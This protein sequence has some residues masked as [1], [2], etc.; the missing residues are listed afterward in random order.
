MATLEDVIKVQKL[1][2]QRSPVSQIN[3]FIQAMQQAQDAKRTRQSADADLQTKYANIAK[4]GV[5]VTKP[6]QQGGISGLLGAL[7]GK[8]QPMYD[9]DPTAYKSPMQQFQSAMGGGTT[10]PRTG[11]VGMPSTGPAGRQAGGMRME[12][13]TMGPSGMS[14]TYKRMTPTAGE[15]KA[16]LASKRGKE[17]ALGNVELVSGA[18]RELAQTYADGYKEGGM[19]SLPKAAMSGVAQWWG[20]APGD[21]FPA[22][23]AFEGQ[24]TEVIGRMMPLLTQQGDKPGSVRLVQTI[25][26]K[27]EK[28]LPRAR[29]GPKSAKSMMTKSIKNMYRFARAAQVLGLNNEAIESMSDNALDA[30]STKVANLANRITITGEEEGALNSLLEQALSPIDALIG[31]RRKEDVSQDEGNTIN[32]LMGML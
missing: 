28:T 8:Q 26:A 12:S 15:E 18:L 16:R 3:Q 29:T 20:G 17:M 10:A 30:V 5:P 24:K 23:A 22:A 25:F 19:G 13:A 27:L 4:T 14:M 7:M 32:E 21:I 11:A 2:Q 1:K 6:Q 9:V 31:G